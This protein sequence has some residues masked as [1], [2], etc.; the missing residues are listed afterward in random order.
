M[1]WNGRRP[2]GERLGLR[3]ALRRLDGVFEICNELSELDRQT[4]YETMQERA[5]QHL[6]PPSHTKLPALD[7]IIQASF[8][9]RCRELAAHAPNYQ[10]A[11]ALLSMA[12]IFEAGADGPSDLATQEASINVA[13]GTVRASAA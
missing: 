3:I 5:L 7:N 11:N 6:T 1:S 2:F 13:N 10:I 12:Q 9:D 8:S 4:L